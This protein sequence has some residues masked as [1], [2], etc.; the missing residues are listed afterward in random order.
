M[1]PEIAKRLRDLIE[2][3]R[4][5]LQME[6]QTNNETTDTERVRDVPFYFMYNMIIAKL[7]GIHDEL[8]LAIARREIRVCWGDMPQTTSI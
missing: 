5:A 1:E 3:T 7:S 6:A 2:R 8:K 4:I